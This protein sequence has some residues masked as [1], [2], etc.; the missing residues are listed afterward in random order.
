MSSERMHEPYWQHRYVFER[1]DALFQGPGQPGDP[2]GRAYLAG[3]QTNDRGLEVAETNVRRQKRTFRR[4][5]S[6]SRKQK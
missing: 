6:D 3:A 1:N 5:R 2:V 4:V